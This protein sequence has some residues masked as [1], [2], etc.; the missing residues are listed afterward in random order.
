M[1]TRLKCWT[2][3]DEASHK[4]S[5]TVENDADLGM[6]Q[7]AIVKDRKKNAFQDIDADCLILRKVTPDLD[8]ESLDLEVIEGIGD[9]AKK[10][11]IAKKLDDSM[12]IA[13]DFPPEGVD[14]RLHIIIVPYKRTCL[15][16]DDSQKALEALNAVYNTIWGKGDVLLK[17]QTVKHDEE[18]VRDG[19]IK[20]KRYIFALEYMRN[21]FTQQKR[22]DK[23]GFDVVGQSGTDPSF[24]DIFRYGVSRHNIG[25][26]SAL[27]A[28][29]DIWSLCDTNEKVTSPPPAFLRSQNARIIQA[30]SRR[31]DRWYPWTRRFE[32]SKYV[33]DIWTDD[34]LALLAYL[35]F[36]TYSTFHRTGAHGPMSSFSYDHHPE[37]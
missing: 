2:L 23:S 30:A 24:P 12:S 8:S 35:R 4:G 33:M 3:G 1:T 26:S 7:D 21:V 32:G 17:A 31:R 13:A 29:E 25:D 10:P 11:K 6:L 18:V 5:V 37:P 9:I 15:P 22:I 14:K 27:D 16:D 36:G 34:E 28:H 19:E 20:H